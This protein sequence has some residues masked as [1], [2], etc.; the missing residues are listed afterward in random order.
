ML[1]GSFTQHLGPSGLCHSLQ[2]PDLAA[3]QANLLP[4]LLPLPLLSPRLLLQSR[5]LTEPLSGLL[6][7]PLP[8]TSK[9]ICLPGLNKGKNSI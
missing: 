1:T 7:Q 6:L 9:L 4:Q 8:L 5:R 2:G 3:E